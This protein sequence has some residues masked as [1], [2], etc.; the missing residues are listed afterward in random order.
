MVNPE[1]KIYVPL[2][3]KNRPDLEKAAFDEAWNLNHEIIENE[4]LAGRIV[5]G[6][7]ESLHRLPF[8]N[9]IYYF[10]KGIITMGGYLISI[11]ERKMPRKDF[12]EQSFL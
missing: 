4:Y 11:E 9:L 12:R 5:V 6:R 3:D 2:G 7:V 10:K 1:R 8:I